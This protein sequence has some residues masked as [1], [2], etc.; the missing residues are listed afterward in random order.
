MKQTILA[1]ALVA[2]L[3][4]LARAE[5]GITNRSY[6]FFF[7]QI[8]PSFPISDQ[9][10]SYYVAVGLF[11]V[12]NAQKNDKVTLYTSIPGQ[13]FLW[14]TDLSWYLDEDMPHYASSSLW[15]ANEVTA[16]TDTF[17]VQGIAGYYSPIEYTYATYTYA[18][19]TS[20]NVYPRS[21]LSSFSYVLDQELQAFTTYPVPLPDGTTATITISELT[22]PEPSTYALL[23]IGAMGLLMV[24]RKKKSA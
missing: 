1:L 14:S 4:S 5:V 10:G 21:V 16:N 18:D 8:K 22:I 2:G 17:F 24:L 6:P 12:N 13:I 19:G 3:T 15:V 20:T 7:E 9:Y 23:G 11:A